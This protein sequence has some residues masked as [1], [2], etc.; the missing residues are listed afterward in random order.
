MRGF[1]GKK[2]KKQNQPRSAAKRL[3]GSRAKAEQ[4][5]AAAAA[6]GKSRGRAKLSSSSAS[7]TPEQLCPVSPQPQRRCGEILPCPRLHPW[8][9]TPG[10]APEG[11]REKQVL[12]LPS[13]GTQG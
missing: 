2:K 9:N 12:G 7:G 11:P 5:P 13:Q 6:E 10:I 3:V 4:T 1:E 8:E